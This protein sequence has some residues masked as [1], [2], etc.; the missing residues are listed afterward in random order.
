MFVLSDVS[1]ELGAW[2][3]LELMFLAWV[4][5]GGQQFCAGERLTAKMIRW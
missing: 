3:G 1:L 5:N 2:L 4:G